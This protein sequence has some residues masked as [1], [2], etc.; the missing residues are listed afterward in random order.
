MNQGRPGRGQTFIP[1]EPEQRIEI[2]DLLRGFA[3]LGIIFYNMLFFS[4]YVFAHFSE[5]KRLFDF[6]LNE[7]IYGFLDIVITAKFYTLF[8][9]L[10]AVGFFIQ[11]NKHGGDGAGFLKTYRR[12]LYILF[13]IGLAHSL[14]W[15][16]DILLTYSLIA[17][18]MIL[19]RNVRPKPLLRWSVF[20]LTLPLL[21]DMALLP[22]AGSLHPVAASPISSAHVSYPDV[23]PSAVIRTFQDGTI[24]EV[25]ILNAHNIVWKYL[26]YFPSGGYFTYLG[27]FLLG[28][29]LAS[30]G[31]FL[32]KRIST[33]FWLGCMAIGFAATLAAKAL[34]GNVYLFPPTLLN[35]LYKA[36]LTVGQIFVCFF[37]IASVFRISQMGIGKKISRRL[38]PVGRM[39]LSNYLLQ[40]ILMVAIFYPFGLGLIGRIGLIPTSCI[41]ISVLMVEIVISNAWLN[42]FRFGPMEWLWRSLTYRKW[43]R[44]RRS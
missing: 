30:I 7:R 40:T 37:Y 13:T 21:I 42:R 39:A 8:S 12:R 33:R 9:I 28:Y 43:I 26:S 10:F 29:Y 1:V 11:L 38:I 17:L 3:L 14:V 2:L 18:V 44:N 20:F 25:F 34:G 4:G 19:F 5:L 22:F 24:A 32:K 15:Y 16:G 31:F 6:A 36:L 27:I 35:A 23:D 41:A